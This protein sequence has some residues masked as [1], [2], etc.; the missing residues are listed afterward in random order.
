MPL[1]HTRNTCCSG[2][3]RLLDVKIQVLRSL[4]TLVDMLAVALSKQCA[5]L[6]RI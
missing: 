3:R 4:E 1:V 2:M 5:F 6:I